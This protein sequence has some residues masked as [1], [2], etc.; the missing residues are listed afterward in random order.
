MALSTIFKMAHTFIPL[1]APD[2]YFARLFFAAFD[3]MLN[4]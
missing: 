3:T 1:I 2:D 4:I